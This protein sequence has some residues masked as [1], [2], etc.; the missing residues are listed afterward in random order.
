MMRL[1]TIMLAL[2][3]ATTCSAQTQAATQTTDSV[4]RI[5]I[6]VVTKTGAPIESVLPEYQSDEHGP[7][8]YPSE[9][10]LELV[11]PHRS[12]LFSR[13]KEIKFHAT[14]IALPTGIK[15][16]H[17]EKDHATTFTVYSISGKLIG[18]GLKHMPA[19]PKGI[20]I[21]NGQKLIVK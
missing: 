5:A 18:T 21:V 11:N 19:L 15:T 17:N 14:K 9:K 2:L 1:S 7:M 8:I 4:G 13:I 6:T 20:Y 10:R 16:I 3:F 12:I